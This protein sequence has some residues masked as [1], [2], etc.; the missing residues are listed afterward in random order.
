M[1]G[2]SENLSPF[3]DM[4][5]WASLLG[6]LAVLSLGAVVD[7]KC[8]NL[9]SRSEIYPLTQQM[10]TDMVGLGVKHQHCFPASAQ[11]SG[12]RDCC[13]IPVSE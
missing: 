4:C 13:H 5:R 8:G 1:P 9:P 7:P 11:C 12:V 6:I 2:T 10:I 3:G